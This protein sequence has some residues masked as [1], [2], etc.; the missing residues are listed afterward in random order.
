[1][2][3]TLFFLVVL[4]GAGIAYVFF[5]RTVDPTA[6]GGQRYSATDRAQGLHCQDLQLRSDQPVQTAL[7][8]RIGKQDDQD[9][10]RVIDLLLGSLQPGGSHKLT[11]TYSLDRVGQPTNLHKATGTMMN[12]DC[13]FTIATIER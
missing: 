4:G 7:Q 10:V 1:M 2:L 11:V 9:H 5:A 12:S 3:R 8:D 6:F 13:S